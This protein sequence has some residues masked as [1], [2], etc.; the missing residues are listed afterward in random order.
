MTFWAAISMSLAFIVL[1]PACRAKSSASFATLT[2][3]S[4]RAFPSA[5]ALSSLSLLLLF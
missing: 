3:I 4:S 2:P 1:R 5:I